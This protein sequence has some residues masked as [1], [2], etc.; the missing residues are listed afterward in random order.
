M[1]KNNE[2][3][4][5]KELN[6]ENSSL[7][8]SNTDKSEIE[9]LDE[10]ESNVNDTE[11]S[12]VSDSE[13]EVDEKKDEDK[14]NDKVNPV[15]VVIE[16]AI[17]IVIFIFCIKIVPEYILQ[18]TVV[19]GDSM[20]NNYYNNDSLFVEKV[21]KHFSD[22]DRF[23]VIVFYP[24]P[25][26]NDDYYIKRVIGLPGETIQIS[27]GKIYINGKVLEED[28]GKNEIT[29][30]GIAADPVKLG[31]DEFFVLGDNRKISMDSRYTE[32]GVVKKK[33]IGGVVIFRIYPFN[34]FGKTK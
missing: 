10:K 29:Y 9:D 18:R 30:E 12:D 21:S 32:V 25:E 26:Q 14:E 7:E 33:N 6:V 15:S 23:D 27:D 28:Y 2:D 13:D 22:P 20:L 1:A 19:D 3:L 34:R 31:E 11:V 8:E 17:Y 16:I 5:V 4:D 24:H